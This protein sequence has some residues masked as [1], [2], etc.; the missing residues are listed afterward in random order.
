MKK[1]IAILICTIEGISFT[2]KIV[3]DQYHFLEACESSIDRAGRGVYLLKKRFGI[4][5]ETH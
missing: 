5:E 3:L 2:S 1:N 4:D